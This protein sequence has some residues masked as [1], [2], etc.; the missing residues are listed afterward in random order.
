MPD[1]KP[2]PHH[3]D[4]KL[5]IAIHGKLTHFD[6]RHTNNPI[7]LDYLSMIDPSR[8]RLRDILVADVNTITPISIIPPSFKAIT[9]DNT[10]MWCGLIESMVFNDKLFNLFYS[11]YSGMLDRVVNTTIDSGDSIIYREYKTGYSIFHTAAKLRLI[12]RLMNDID[13]TIGQKITGLDDELTYILKCYGELGKVFNNGN[14]L[15]ITYIEDFSGTY[16]IDYVTAYV[17]EVV[18][19]SL[20]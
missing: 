3:T 13:K 15:L 4:G 5:H 2:T 9:H 20:F 14:E 17:D 1:F 11:E 18:N 7:V 16:L 6:P 8:S 19:S 10:I 12:S